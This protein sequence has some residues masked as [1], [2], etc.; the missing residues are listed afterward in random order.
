MLQDRACENTHGPALHR[1]SV[2]ME[3]RMKKTLVQFIKFGLVGV[4]NT[5]VSY[6]IYAVVFY[7]S[8]NYLLANVLSWLL[9]VLHAYLWQNIFV[10]RQEENAGKRVWWQVLL[11]TYAAYAFTGLILNNILLWLWID[12]IDISRFC[13]GI[14]EGLSG[15]G[16][17]MTSRQFAGYAGPL[18]N[19]VFSIPINFVMN[20]FWAYKQK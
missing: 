15:M 2:C 19:M 10:F 14:I 16:L 4:S 3:G 7:L 8:E 17:L 20:K 18:L 12:V 13:G 11:K 1:K 9:S 6:A 5:I